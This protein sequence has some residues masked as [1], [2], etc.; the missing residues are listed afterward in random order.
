MSLYE[1]YS[2]S[3]EKI[4][5]GG[6]AGSSA[7]AV[8]VTSLLWLRTTLN[9]QY[10]NGITTTDALKQLYKQGGISRFY[11]GYIP[12]LILASSARFTD[13]FA[14]V[15]AL[16]MT[17]HTNMPLY[18]KT[19]MSSIVAGC[20]RSILMPL[21]VIK[22]NYQVKGKKGFH[23]VKENIK[24]NGKRVL[25]NGTMAQ[26]TAT[27]VGHFP[28]FFTYNYL[29]EKYPPRE[30][31][32]EELLKQGAIGFCSSLSSDVFV[33]VFKVMK[34]TK[35]TVRSDSSYKDIITE[36]IK[37]D[38]IFGIYRGFKTKLIINGINGMLFSVCWKL[39]R[40]N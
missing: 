23:I 9:Y 33:N 13:T 35:Q 27:V 38:G 20:C 28:W 16:E 34:T 29:N 8:Q 24:K 37:K 11:R 1:I 21:D 26:C 15:G 32:Y 2:K 3:R 12:A 4:I 22:T 40:D 30:N 18:V 6:L 7:A 10:T 19:G 31:K 14:N 17:K 5:K 25:W 39:L 36:I